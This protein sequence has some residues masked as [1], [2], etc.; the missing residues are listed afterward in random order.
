MQRDAA[1]IAALSSLIDTGLDLPPDQRA[2]WIEQLPAEHDSLKPS[3]RKLLSMEKP[4]QDSYTLSDVSRQVHAAMQGAL[5]GEEVLEFAGGARIGPYELIRE[6]GRGGMGTVWLARRTEGLTRR[7]VALK[8]PHAGMLHAEFSARMER[9]RDILESLAHPNIARLYDAGVTAAGQPYLALEYIE[10]I[11]I[12]VYCD[13]KRLGVRERIRLFVQ[14][15]QAIQYAHSHLV[16]HRDLKPANILVTD[17][18]NAVVLDFGIAKL[19]TEG[20]TAETALTQFGGRALTPD[21]ASPEQI[22]GAPLTTASDVYSLGVML[23][24]LLSKE[25]PYKLTRGSVGE[26]EEAILSADVR[27]PS[28]ATPDKKLARTLRG[29]LDTIVLT[30]M[31][32]KLTDRYRTV[33]AFSLDVEHY[34]GHRAITARPESW[35]EATRRFVARNKIVVGSGL[36]VILALSVGLGTALWQWR[37]AQIESANQKVSKDFVIGLFQSVADNTPAGLSPADATAKQMLDIGTRQLF[38]EHT[39]DSATRLDLLLLMAT[40]NDSL[41]LPDAAIKS[42]DEAIALAKRLYGE[43]SFR[44]AEAFESKAEALLRKGDYKQSMEIGEQTLRLLGRPGSENSALFAK[45]HILLGNVRNQLDP[46]EST[47]PREHLQT[48]LKVLK[49]IDSHT[50][51]V[52]RA[53]FYLARTWE[54]AGEYAKAEPYYRDGI[55]AAEADF[56]KRSYITA[57]GYDN[58]GDLLRHL[59]RYGEAEKYLRAASATYETLYGKNHVTYA[60]SSVNLGLILAAEGQRVEGDQKLADGVASVIAGGGGNDLLVSFFRLH[61]SRMKLAMGE[62][63]AARDLNDATLDSSLARDPTNRR[64]MLITGVEQ[65]QILILL[66]QLDQAAAL[67]DKAMRAYPETSDTHSPRGV[68]LFLREAELAASRDDSRATW[69]GAKAAL[70]LVFDLGQSAEE[71]LPEVLFTNTQALP[72]KELAQAMLSQVEGTSIVRSLRAGEP[73]SVDESIRLHTGLGRLEQ[74]SG[75]LTAARK[76]LDEALRLR[77]AH[78]PPGSAWLAQIQG[79]MAEYFVAA[80]DPAQARAALARAEA[81][82]ARSRDNLPYFDEPIAALRTRLP[83]QAA[84]N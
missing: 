27:R 11:P 24:E 58:Y 10:G 8:L 59:H 66:D 75:N 39:E 15:M 62:F 60:T 80:G 79:M 68:R 32:A 21:Y 74:A 38:A 6:L 2:T 77:L 78:D 30:A 40:L 1:Q 36:A 17:A 81:T 44:Y 3:L 48:A 20:S 82:R 57:F 12:N 9:E 83:A 52:P 50:E 26:L 65:A 29:D 46:P 69:A 76:D 42:N 31:R 54:S 19:T 84:S 23:Y 45:T 49:D 64:Q 34:L 18:G 72:P 43:R 33:D 73:L 5:G 14:V 47:V 61:Q 53:N 67:I 41:D 28:V 37:I 13:A 4:E 7:T 22:A 55:K 35:W 25:R 63:A 16:I 71:L 56:G 51:Q 70:D